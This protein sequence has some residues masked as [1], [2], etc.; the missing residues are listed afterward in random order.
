MT[1]PSQELQTAIEAA[2]AGGK[3]ALNYFQT[4]LD[5]KTKKDSSFVTNADLETEKTI[6]N[7]ILKS[8]PDAKFLA[9]ESGGDTNEKDFWI[10][11]PIDGTRMFI[12]GITQ[13]SILIAHYANNEITSGVCYIPTQDI[14]LVAEKNSAAYLNGKQVTVSTINTLDKAFGSFGSIR[15]YKNIDPIIKLNENKTVLRGFESAY[16][17]ALVAKGSMD[18]V[19]DAYATPWDYAPFIRIIEEA[20]GKVTDFEGKPWNLE[21]KN[22][23]ATN[24]LLHDRVIKVINKN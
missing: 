23:V 3:I 21:T 11:D 18:V 20:G 4:K 14:L 15:H 1:N 24:G 12:K 10:I 7:S 19:I 5:V 9:E 6:K 13:W 2:K 8:Y 16:G 17:L 22:L